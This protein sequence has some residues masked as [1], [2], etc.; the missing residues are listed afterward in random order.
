M[1]YA[2]F[3]LGS[4]LGK[5]FTKLREV[6]Q[7]VIAKSTVS[8][9]LVQYLTANVSANYDRLKTILLGK[10]KGD[11]EEVVYSDKC[12]YEYMRDF[13]TYE[14][15]E[16]RYFVA[17]E[18]IASFKYYNASEWDPYYGGETYYKNCYT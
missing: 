2:V 17:N 4:D 3:L 18:I 15:S 6:E 10:S 1:A 9:S 16:I 5:S 7:G 13:I 11:F 14:I 12:Y 8:L